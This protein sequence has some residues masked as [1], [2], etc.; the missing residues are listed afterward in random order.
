MP[1][2]LPFNLPFPFRSATAVSVKDFLQLYSYTSL[3]FKSINS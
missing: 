1:C 2:L 3:Q